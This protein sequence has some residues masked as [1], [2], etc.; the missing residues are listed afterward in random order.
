MLCFVFI[1]RE[2]CCLFS[3]TI[4]KTLSQTATQT[5]AKGHASK[6]LLNQWY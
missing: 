6:I 4:K 3:F 2:R 1:V 5:E